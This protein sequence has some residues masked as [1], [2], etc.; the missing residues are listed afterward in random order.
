MYVT[1][2]LLIELHDILKIFFSTEANEQGDFVQ[3]NRKRLKILVETITE[4]LVDIYFHKRFVNVPTSL[5]EI[6]NQLGQ[7]SDSDDR[8]LFTALRDVLQRYEILADKSYIDHKP[9]LVPLFQ[10]EIRLLCLNISLHKKVVMNPQAAKL[11]RLLNE[12]K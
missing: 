9:K 8:A 5:L 2:E 12:S 10:K 1:N 7:L 6:N 11:R 4:Q 3:K